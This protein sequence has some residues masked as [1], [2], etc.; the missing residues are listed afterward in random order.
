MRQ[1]TTRS[2]IYVVIG[3][4]LLILTVSMFRRGDEASNA[5]FVANSSPFE[6]LR[7]YQPS[8]SWA[9]NNP[10]QSAAG[11]ALPVSAPQGTV[12]HSMTMQPIDIPSPGIESS[13]FETDS[14]EAGIDIASSFVNTPQSVETPATP[15][16]SEDSYYDLDFETSETPRPN[17][18][19]GLSAS[20]SAGA[21][22]M[23]PLEI[24]Q[25]T[26]TVVEQI[27]ERVS[28]DM[29]A[30]SRISRN[31]HGRIINNHIAVPGGD[32]EDTNLPNSSW[33]KNPFLTDAP[34]DSPSLELSSTN[35]IAKDV[36][37][38][39]AES[40]I[41]S[42]FTESPEDLSIIAD[43]DSSSA[44]QAHTIV[45]S[46][47]HETIPTVIAAE[48]NIES[49]SPSIK[50][51]ISEADAQKAVHNIEYGK[52]LS[53]RGAAYAA[54][55]EFYASLRILAQSHDKQ[56]GG[57]SYTNAL[58]NGILAIK[59]AQ[60]FIVTDTESQIGLS[61]PNTIETHSTKVIS[62]ESA[63]G[64]TAIEAAQRYFAYA[65]HQLSRCGGQNVV[66]AEALYCLGKLHSVQ[67][68]SGSNDS[69]LDL[70]KAM[71]YHQ[72]SISSNG[73][74]FRSLNELGVLYANSGRFAEAKRMLKK[75]LRIKALPQAWQ[76]LAVI[77]Q[78]MGE[79]QLAQLAKREFEMT[80][81]QAP[82]SV[83]RWTPAEEFNKNAPLAKHKASQ[84][85]AI[86]PIPENTKSATSSLRSLG[87][88]ILDSIR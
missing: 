77:H 25:E 28:T 51:G 9:E 6:A 62:T 74:N 88:R 76:N 4:G 13:N 18:N 24:Q 49:S 17:F 80:A 46:V 69:K 27:A 22:I 29:P 72:A 41:L 23:E 34:A 3:I 8:S 50:I 75:S 81:T 70:A 71:I 1:S 12:Q 32:A 16:D 52:S 83:I 33:K 55:Q 65:S 10:D 59:E 44:P 30:F 56:V 14:A 7:D 87:D 66:A 67:A 57:T 43:L 82:I 78:R 5:S 42:E 20:E 39:R 48:D 47:D 85:S 19:D 79:H 84:A 40:M 54:R 31:G 61:V 68:K 35:V 38:P 37:P 60:D 86:L 2:A 21:A 63:Q 36:L 58:R 73:S 15:G 45:P 26:S 53:R 11:Q 64:M